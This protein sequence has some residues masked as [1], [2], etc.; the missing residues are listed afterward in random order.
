MVKVKICG[1]TNLDDALAAVECGAD[2]LGFV[3]APSLRQVTTEVAKEIADRLPPF[4]YRVGVFVN[5]D[6]RKVKQTMAYCHLDLA[7]LHGEEDPDYC[8]ALFPRAIKVFTIKNMPSEKELRQYR[9]AAYMLDIDKGTAF[10]SSEQMRLWQLA[11]RLGEYRPVILAGGLTLSNVGEAIKIARPY[12]VDVSSGVESEPGK[13]DHDKM[14]AF[15]LAAKDDSK[16]K[17]VSQY[18]VGALSPTLRGGRQSAR[19]SIIPLTSIER[20]G[21]DP[22]VCPQVSQYSVGALS[23]T[24]GGGRQSARPMITKTRVK[25]PRYN[26]ENECH[27]V[28]SVTRERKRIFQDINNVEILIETIRFYQERGDLKLLGYVVMPD[29]I[30]LM[31][32]PRK[33]TISDIMRNIKAYSATAIRRR[34]GIDSGIWQDSFY[35]HLICGEK[36]FESKLN[37]LHENPL[38]KGFVQNLD[39]YPYS[40]YI[41]FYTN[42]EP[43]LRTDTG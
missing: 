39:Y 28:T 41:N 26:E 42:R 13:K 15:L 35:D 40:S 22:R 6:L 31:L 11:H 34:T 4:I 38:R 30:H 7:Q 25:L 27:F 29:H 18:S 43:V 12:A 36:D 37:Y 19:P 32:I 3:F 23:P 16:Y 10:K 14:R 17:L 2:A 33:G 8:A 21:A 9:V 24:P 1:I 20:V 5:S